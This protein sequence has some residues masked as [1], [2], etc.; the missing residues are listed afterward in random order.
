MR[1]HFTYL[2]AET[3]NRFQN[4]IEMEFVAP[5]GL[6]NHET[7]GNGFILTVQWQI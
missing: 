7:V 6:L 3:I 4:Q 5:L 1:W 2:P